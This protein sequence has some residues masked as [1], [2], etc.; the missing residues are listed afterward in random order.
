MYRGSR[1]AAMFLLLLT[2]APMAAIGLGLLPGAIAPGSGWVL[3]PLAVAF[4]VAHF[5]AL[6]GIARGRAWARTLAISVAEF[7]GGLSIA[8]AVA[9]LLGASLFGAAEAMATVFG[10][11]AWMTTMYALV[12]ITAGRIQLAGWARR[13]HWWPNPLLRAPA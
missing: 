4:A 6:V 3:V 9:V 7:G 8:A 11:A 10:L 13:S 2:G 1:L 12:G 5:V